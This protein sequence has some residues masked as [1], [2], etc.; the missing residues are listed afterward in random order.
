MC[1]MRG[2]FVAQV[3]IAMKL[4]GIGV[5]VLYVG[6]AAEPA[7][8]ERIEVL[9]E[10]RNWVV[11]GVTADDGSYACRAMVSVPGDSFSIRAFPDQAV[12]L[13]FTSDEWDL[14]EGDTASI[15]VEIDSRSPW[16]FADATLLQNSVFVDLPD[17]AESKTFVS[18][19]ARGAMLQLR[20]A[21]GTGVRNYSLSGS[22]EAIRN[23]NQCDQTTIRDRNPFN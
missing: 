18:Q 9:F 15:E 8:A 20:T 3:G 16:A 14:G 12:R 19:V 1:E 22:S 4:L 21:D 5:I 2:A 13:Q 6:L 23:L 17:L 11:E 7:S 10:F